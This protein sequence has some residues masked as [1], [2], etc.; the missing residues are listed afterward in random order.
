M[1][2]ST[3]ALGDQSTSGNTGLD[4]FYDLAK[5]P[6]H[7]FPDQS[8]HRP[9]DTGKPRMLCCGHSLDKRLEEGM[10]YA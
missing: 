6:T 7:K 8:G 1:V 3:C 10:T 9:H 2:K 5:I 4:R